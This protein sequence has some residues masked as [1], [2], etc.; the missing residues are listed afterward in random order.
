MA[1]NFDFARANRNTPNENGW[2]QRWAEQGFGLNGLYPSAYDAWRAVPS[3][4]AGTPPSDGNYYLIYFDG[5]FYG[6]RYGDVAVYRNGRVWSGS[7]VKWR[8]TSTTLAGYKAWIGTP[9]LGWSE[10]CGAKRIATIPPATPQRIAKKGTATVTTPVLNVRNSPSTGSKVQA[11]YKKGEKFNY[12]SY[13]DTGGYRWLSY[14]SVSTKVRR[15][16]A[17]KKLGGESYVKGGV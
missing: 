17:Q 12:D 3:K 4:R 1:N 7:N 14:I 10:F 16:V 6:H 2:C 15:Y 13:I 5:W 11:T 9:Y 8:T